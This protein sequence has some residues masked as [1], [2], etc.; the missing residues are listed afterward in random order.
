MADGANSVI[1]CTKCGVA[2]P[3]NFHASGAS[4]DCPACGAAL[5]VEVFPALFS[6][7]ARFSRAEI[8]IA[9]SE[10]ACFFH[11]EKKAVVPCSHC[12][13]FL[14]ALCDVELG[15]EHLCPPCLETARKKRAPE[16]WDT[17]RWQGRDHLLMVASS[18]FTESYQR[19]FFRDVQAVVV[20]RT[21]A[22]IA[23][24]GVFGGLALLCALPVAMA[25]AFSAS[26]SGG[27]WATP[28]SVVF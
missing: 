23:W 25:L 11:A 19:F 14:C 27:D 28:V 5:Q 1:P 16:K 18:G 21:S 2:L 4:G 12:G 26:G 9:G 6:Q 13:R 10:A 8:A 22:G 3:W 7:P 15:N 24:N 20:R 17:R